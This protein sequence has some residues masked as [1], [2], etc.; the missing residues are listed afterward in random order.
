MPLL[1]IAA[2]TFTRGSAIA[3]R[4]LDIVLSS[5]TLIA[6]AP[7]LIGVAIAIKLDSRG[8]VLF[9]QRRSGRGG[10]FF[11]LYKF[12]SM[13][14]DAMVEVRVD[15]AIVKHDRRRRGSRASAAS[16]GA[17][18]STRRRSSSTSCGAT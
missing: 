8:P 10:T 12:R 5:L 14:V 13:H 3:K 6:L 9:V 7:L 15:G 1:S 2:P 17:S 4:A 11:A 16:S 18:R